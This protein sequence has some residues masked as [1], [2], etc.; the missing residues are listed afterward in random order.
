VNTIRV[1]HVDDE[2]DQLNFTKTFLAFSAPNLQLESVL[3]PE[4]ALARLAEEEYDCI[5]SDYQL[6]GLDG[7]ELA[8]KIRETSDIPIIIYTGRGSEEVA[9]A[10]FTVGVDD[11]LRKETN[12]SHYH[13]LAKRIK[14]SVER[15]KAENALVESEKK[16]RSLVQSS[17]DGVMVFTGRELMYAN[18]QAAALHGFS[19]V[20]ELIEFEPSNLL[21]PKDRAR[22]EERSL[23]RQRGEDI[24]PIS[25]FRL[26]LPDGTMRTVQSSS[27]VIQYAGKTSTLAFLRD[28]TERKRMEEELRESEARYRTLVEESPNAISITVGDEIV[29]ANPRRAE[30]TGYSDV[31]EVIGTNGLDRI[32]PMDREMVRLRVE[33][34]ARGKEVP[35]VQELRMLRADGG[36]VHLVDH[37]SEVDWQG[38][39]A[40]LHT[41]QDITEYKRVEKELLDSESRLR[42]VTMSSPDHIIMLDT[43]ANI[44]FINYIV[45]DLAPEQVIGTS[46][47]NYISEEFHQTTQECFERVLKTGDPDLYYTEYTIE[48]EAHYF[49]NTVGPV[50]HD[51]D[52]VGL[53]V[54]ARDITERRR[55]E[56]KL[57]ASEER[58]SSFMDSATDGFALLDSQLNFVEVN[59]ASLKMTG[60]SRDDL[61]GKNMLKL[62]PYL[63]ETGR[64]DEYRKVIES[65]EPFF[66]DDHVFDPRF[67]GIHVALSVFKVGDGLG[68][69]H[70]DI[71][72]RKQMEEELR[73]SEERHRSLLEASMDA[74]FVL[75]ETSYLYVNRRAADLLGFDEPEELVGRKAFDFV[76]PEDRDMVRENAI[77]RQRGEDVPSQYQ[78][79]LLRRDGSKIPVE[80]MATSIVYEGKQASLSMI[81]DIT[82]RR[83]YEDQLQSLH[84]HA[85]EL[86]R[87]ESPEEI[88]NITYEAMD[89][90]LGFDVIDVIKV[91]DGM[92]RDVF[93][94]GPGREPLTMS[95][96]GVGVTARAARTGEPQYVPDATRDPDYFP[97]MI[98]DMMSEFAVPV[99]VEGKAVAVLNA[100]NPQ[101]DAI[102]RRDRALLE[103]LAFHM[104]SAFTRL[105]KLSERLG[106]EERLETLHIHAMELGATETIEEVAE[107]TMN[108]IERVLGFTQGGFAIVE[109]DRLR[110]IHIVG[111]ETWRP[112]D[113]SLDGKGITVRAVRTGRTQLVHDIREDED[114]IL[115]PGGSEL[116]SLSELDVPVKVE[117]EV[118][119]VINL[120]SGKLHAFTGSDK[121]LIETLVMHVSSALNRLK[122]LDTLEKLVEE[123]TREVLNLEQMSAAGKMAAMVGH[124]LRGPLQTIKNSLYLMERSPENQAELRESM[125]EAVD[126]AASMLEEL[127]LNIGD[128]PLQLQEAN[129]GA[130]IQKAVVEAS[131]PDSVEPE[132]HIAD[133]LDSVSMDPLKIRRVLDNLIRNAVEAMPDGGALKVSADVGEDG[134][135]ITVNDTGTGIPEELIPV[136]FKVFI[137]TKSKGMGLGLAYCKR[138]V[139]A[140][141]GTIDVE[142]SLGNGTTMTIQLPVTREHHIDEN[143]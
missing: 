16:Y 123:R 32:A 43:D 94:K 129:L 109:G 13:V 36:V 108:A 23:A 70:T 48:G 33:A 77:R 2:P 82:E 140:H 65:G 121:Q 100:E 4:K 73:K 18:Q 62:A 136:L 68:I 66:N 72:D 122:R 86:S 10:A 133:G 27:S 135:E 63:E 128:T 90:T 78:F 71:T 131:I 110:F 97:G 45:P 137:T 69:I 88:F 125:D 111:A 79:T 76:A 54:N 87:I 74:V 34:R 98:D 37:E 17:M 39:K 130:L 132:L 107:S 5:V 95:M 114:F 1:L 28:V 92:L 30:L 126:Y 81:R 7:I 15:Q 31:S 101:V 20:V 19:S 52:I 9:E 59:K 143:E 105:R 134:T 35:V 104:A 142:S 141:G 25:E 64:I 26:E 49:E 50:R 24:A 96:T 51:E 6:P 117:G 119:S 57:R 91:E 29:Y 41:L 47:Y 67:G 22:I 127:R 58:L 138:A 118:V 53:I 113:M 99:L 75:D 85:T 112:F 139:E 8:R 21:H 103:T 11:Y 116:G 14:A 12:P 124:D 106:Y 60:M 83:L 46:I 93:V 56:Q 55:I 40:L 115:G 42:S 80:T 120:E 38:Q 61:I 44:Q 102:T 84:L 89:K 3:T